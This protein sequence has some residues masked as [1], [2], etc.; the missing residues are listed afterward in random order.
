MSLLR[1]ILHSK[2][3]HVHSITQHATL[4]DAV[5]Q[6]VKKNLG[7]LVVCEGEGD[8]SQ[9]VGIITE[10][11]ILRACAENNSHLEQ[12]RISQVMT[13]EII[14]CAPDD[15]VQDAMGAMTNHRIRHLPIMDDDGSL[16]G[17]VSIGDLVKHQ[18]DQLTMENHYLKSYIHG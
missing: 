16:M 5:Q 9:M 10:R 13:R 1:E 3:S 17:I 11:D 14:T 8:A 6:L 18:H 7:S 12:I 4:A 2:G 15:T